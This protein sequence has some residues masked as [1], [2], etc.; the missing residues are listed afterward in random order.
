MTLQ[1]SDPEIAKLIGREEKRQREGLEMIPSENYVSAAVRQATGSVLANKYSEGYPGKRYYQGNGII[2]AIENLAIARFKKLFNVAFVNVQPYSGSPA[3]A[4]VYFAL[5]ALGDKIMGMALSSGGHLT[6]GHPKITFSGKYFNSVQYTVDENG[7]INY[8]KLQEQV[9]I[10][11][12]KILVCGTTSY[13]RVLEFARFKKIAD[14]VGAILLA[15]ISHIA[16][17]VVAG[18]H[19]SP[20]PFADV[21]MTTTHKT[22]RGPRGAILMTNNEEMAAKI[23]RAVFPGL[24]GGP[25]ENVIAAMAVAAKEAGTSEFRAYAKQIV[26]NAKVLSEVIIKNKIALVSGGTDN[27]LIMI[28]L[29]NFGL[30]GKDT[31]EKLEEAGIVTNKNAVPNDPLPPAISSGIRLGT[32]AITTRGMKEPEMKLIGDW[33]ADVI[34]SRRPVGAVKKDVLDLCRK[35]PI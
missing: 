2:D 4:A 19:P 28:D 12:P 22:L 15:D 25:H 9:L 34:F 7:W 24:Q 33:I 1:K 10:E 18:V 11:K 16:G 3:N 14:S 27:H 6:H 35:F 26:A 31:A 21:V 8:D 20:I 17:L 32:P 23:D 13:P 30:T 5:L 29:K